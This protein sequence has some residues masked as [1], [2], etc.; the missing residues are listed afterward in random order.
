MTMLKPTRRQFLAGLSLGAAALTAPRALWA[1]AA[2]APAIGVQLYML[3]Q[4]LAD[5]LTGTLDAVAALG[6]KNLE[7]AGYYDHTATQMKA[8]LS[9]RGLNPVSAHCLMASMSDDKAKEAIDYGAELGLKTVVAAIPY[10]RL[11]GEGRTWDEA[12][13]GVSREDFLHS[14][15]RFNRFGELAQAAGLVFA[16]HNHAFD[17]TQFDG[18]HGLDILLENTDAGLVKFQLDVGNTAMAGI[19]PIAYFEAHKSRVPSV[20]MKD[21]KKPFTP[22]LYDMPEPTPVGNGVLDLPLLVASLTKAGVGHMFIEQENMPRELELVALMANAGN[23][24]A[25]TG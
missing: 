15:E 23:L 8:V 21:W 18:V 7:F 20:H 2:S 17:F 22:S 11:L 25:F 5:D 14:A 9:D 16:Y 19:N 1:S 3:K 24:G 10:M 6:V 12:M 13:R 4:S